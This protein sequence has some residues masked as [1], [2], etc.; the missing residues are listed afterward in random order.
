[1]MVVPNISSGGTIAVVLPYDVARE[2][3]KALSDELHGWEITE[4]MPDGTIRE[5]RSHFDPGNLHINIH[6]GE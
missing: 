2:L 5:M 6:Q 3:N 1:M 4:Q